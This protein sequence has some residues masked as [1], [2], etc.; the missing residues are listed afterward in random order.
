MSRSPGPGGGGGGGRLGARRGR[1]LVFNS[2]ELRGRAAEC[3]TPSCQPG[4]RR[5]LPAAAAHGSLA[6][7]TQV[8]QDTKALRSPPAQS[9]TNDICTAHLKE[10][11]LKVEVAF[12]E[13]I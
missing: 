7:Q 5:H 13:I 3:A 8:R 11:H 6:P 10:T 2:R 1:V 4:K 12:K 9:C